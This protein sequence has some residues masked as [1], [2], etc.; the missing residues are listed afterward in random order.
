MMWHHCRAVPIGC[1]KKEAA[2]SPEGNKAI[3]KVFA[4]PYRLE[5]HG[6]KRTAGK[7]S[8]VLAYPDICFAI[9]GSHTSF[10]QLVIGFN[11]FST[12]EELCR[13]QD[14][15]EGEQHFTRCQYVQ[16]WEQITLK[17]LPGTEAIPQEHRSSC[18]I[19][20]LTGSWWGFGRF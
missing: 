17:W 3:G 4:S 14:R 7:E 6:F 1:E 10:D 12:S 20:F 8:M 2:A 16:S 19:H 18:L 9:D 11:L 15:N 13:Q 5:V